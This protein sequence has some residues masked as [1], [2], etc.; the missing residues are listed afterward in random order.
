[1][2]DASGKHTFRRAIPER[3]SLRRQNLRG[4]QKTDNAVEG[5]TLKGNEAQESIG[6]RSVETRAEATDLSM[7]KGLEVE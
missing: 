2:T 4:V 6:P 1:V 3:K 5:R 7:E